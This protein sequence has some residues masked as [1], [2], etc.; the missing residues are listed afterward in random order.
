MDEGQA[1]ERERLAEARKAISSGIPVPC[2][3]DPEAP[4]LA[5]EYICGECLATL[6]MRR[7]S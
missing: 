6:R 4:C 2:V 7:E 1:A 3:L 5:V